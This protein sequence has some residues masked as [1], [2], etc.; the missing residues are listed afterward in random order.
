MKK[1]RYKIRLN[2]DGKIK[3]TDN[4]RIRLT[5]TCDCGDCSA[6]REETSN[7]IMEKLVDVVEPLIKKGIYIEKMSLEAASGRGIVDFNREGVGGRIEIPCYKINRE[8]MYE[9]ELI[10]KMEG[11][12]NELL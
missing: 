9:Y 2:S 8:S 10:E 1:D 3:L 12:E 6:K 5:E 7:L 11:G 4:C